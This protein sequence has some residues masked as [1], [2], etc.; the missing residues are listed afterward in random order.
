ML[1]CVC[2]RKRG[3]HLGSVGSGGFVRS[4]FKR[5]KQLTLVAL[6][7]SF[8]A[9]ADLGGFTQLQGLANPTLTAEPIA[10][11]AL[12]IP[13]SYAVAAGTVDTNAPGFTARVHRLGRVRGPGDPDSIENAERQLAD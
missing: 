8:L 10:G 1:T 6:S 7:V 13:A 2:R 9:G 12:R 3:G 5:T 4:L 11:P